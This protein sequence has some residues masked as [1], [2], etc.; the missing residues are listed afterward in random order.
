MDLG[1]GYA[2]LQWHHPGCEWS[3]SSAKDSYQ[4]SLCKGEG[5]GFE[6]MSK[7]VGIFQYHFGH[8]FWG[9]CLKRGSCMVCVKFYWVVVSCLHKNARFQALLL[10][11][12]EK[13]WEEIRIKNHSGCLAIN[14]PITQGTVACIFSREDS[15]I[16]LYSPLFQHPT[17]GLRHTSPSWPKNTGR[18][19]W[20]NN[21]RRWTPVVT[22]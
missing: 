15:L 12:P 6:S 16:I 3:S 7:T 13:D 1:L 9:A 14:A 20:V 2:S 10:W 18:L 21:S 19:Q 17:F 11:E 22:G 5:Q 4:R 8:R